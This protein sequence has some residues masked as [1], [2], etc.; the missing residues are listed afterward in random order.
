MFLVRSVCAIYTVYLLPEVSLNI[1]ISQSEVSL[2][3]FVTLS[4]ST[5]RQDDQSVTVCEECGRKWL[6]HPDVGIA[7]I[8]TKI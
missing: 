7:G 1:F 3:L 5:E 2:H 4:H 8:P 6:G